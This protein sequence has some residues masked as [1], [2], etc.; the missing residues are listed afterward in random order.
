M[1]IKYIQEQLGVVADGLWGNVSHTALIQALRQ[2]KVIRASNNFT[3][4][5]L[6]H[7]R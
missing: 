1:T 5:E 3:V 4:N 6:L 7:N 2:G